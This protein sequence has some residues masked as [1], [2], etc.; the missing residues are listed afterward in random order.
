LRVVVAAALLFQVA[1]D[2][3]SHV[4]GLESHADGR[5]AVHQQRHRAGRKKGVTRQLMLTFDGLHTV[6]LVPL[7]GAPQHLRVLGQK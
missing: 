7:D 4:V 6:G 5:R 2:R 3:K 1:A